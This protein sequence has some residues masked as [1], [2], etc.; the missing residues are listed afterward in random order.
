MRLGQLVSTSVS[1]VFMQDAQTFVI[2]T[3]YVSELPKCMFQ[4][5]H[6][7]EN[8]DSNI[9]IVR[10]AYTRTH[11]TTRKTFGPSREFSSIQLKYPR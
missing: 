2:K 4:H 3:A 5:V 7:L 11:I 8:Y 6:D 9:C 10:F 1:L